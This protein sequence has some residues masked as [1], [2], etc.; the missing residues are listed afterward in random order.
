MNKVQVKFKRIKDG[1]QLPKA[2]TQGSVGI[3]LHAFALTTTGHKFKILIP[4]NTTKLIQ[5]GF[6]IEPPS[7]FMLFLCSRSGLA[8]HSLFVLNAPGIIDPDYRGELMV[9]LHN[10]GL[11]TQIISHGDRVA[12]LIGLTASFLDPI[13]VVDLSRTERGDAGFGSTGL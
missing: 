11:E 12:Q 1:A 4:P 5:T 10:A 2:W 8:K 9:L 7:G 3:D 6:A 13:E